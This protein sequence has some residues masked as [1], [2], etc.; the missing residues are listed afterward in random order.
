ML[1]R[2]FLLIALFGMLLVSANAFEVLV[3]RSDRNPAY[4][5]ASDLLVEELLRRGVSRSDIG[6]QTVTEW[7]QN[8][9]VSMGA[10]VWLAVGSDA[11][12]TLLAVPNRPPVVASMLPKLAYDRTL[13]EWGG[14][15]AGVTAVY[16]DQP[17]P[18]VLAAARAAYPESKRVGVLWGNESVLV[19]NAFQTAAHEQGF[20][21]R[22]A[23]VFAS[24]QIFAALQSVLDDTQLLIAL[25]DPLVYNASSV[26]N[27]LLTSYRV[28]VP[29]LAFSPA[30]VRAGALL[31]LYTTPKQ[32]APQIVAQVMGVLS[33]NSV[34]AAQ[35]PQDF[36]IDVNDYVAKSLG[37]ATSAAV[38]TE[39]V[40]RMEAIKP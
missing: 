29:V 26:S 18:R 3:V 12:S 31:A 24:T 10:K 20:A 2:F 13:R 36:T 21:V 4:A 39:R 37:F 9:S 15:S 25:A 16:F 7:Q 11:L 22:S 23:Q 6:L 27:I 19:S 14:R 38:L 28:G 5:E 8:R 33:S 40:K 32:L 34:P 30:Y 17:L 35:F 1:R